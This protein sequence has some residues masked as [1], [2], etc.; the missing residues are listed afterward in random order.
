MVFRE[1]VRFAGPKHQE[2]TSNLESGTS[3]TTKSITG[4]S[5]RSSEGRK[6]RSFKRFLSISTRICSDKDNDSPKESK[7]P[8]DQRY[9]LLRYLGH[10]RNGTV[11]LSEDLQTKSLVAIKTVIHNDPDTVPAEVGILQYL[12]QHANIVQLLNCFE[13]PT[14]K[15][16]TRIVFEHCE[17][18][19]LQEYSS[20]M[21]DTPPLEPFLWHITSEISRG[22]EFL[23]SKNVVHGDLK[24]SNILLRHPPGLNLDSK[25]T[26]PRFPVLKIADFGNAVLNAPGDIPQSHLSTWCYGAPESGGYFGPE[27]DIWALGCIVHRLAHRKFPRILIP[28]M[29]QQTE[30]EAAYEDSDWSNDL[31]EY[32]AYLRTHA[33]APTRFDQP[34]S[35]SMPRSKL[36]QYF[37]MR[38]L[39]SDYKKRITAHRL[40]QYVLTIAEL[41]RNIVPV[42]KNRP[43]TYMSTKQYRPVLASFDSNKDTT[44]SSVIRQVFCS[45][46]KHVVTYKKEWL[47]LHVMQ[48]LPL[49]DSADEEIA[50]ELL[51]SLNLVAVDDRT[52]IRS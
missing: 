1:L 22:L 13:H 45:F 3:Q 5:K 6:L 25:S 31:K 39:E 16:W 14:R 50:T 12:G 30:D 52:G 29:D 9:E 36:L 32:R 51:K 18:G 7:I 19:D 2:S 15:D 28:D 44:D 27:I 23:H 11:N 20:K 40:C 33:F 49:L 4:E 42:D 41:I 46:M 17:V 38:A 35:H 21:G 24:L 10:E 37:M 48:L 26:E 43:V 8:P 34:T 47:F